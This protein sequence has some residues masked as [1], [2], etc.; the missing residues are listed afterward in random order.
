M[1]IRIITERYNPEI[2]G[3][4]MTALEQAQA[5]FDVRGCETYFFVQD[6]VQHVSFVLQMVS[7]TKGG[8]EVAGGG[9]AAAIAKHGGKVWISSDV[10]DILERLPQECRPAFSAL[11]TWRNDVAD[12]MKVK[13]YTVAENKLLERLALLVPQS[14]SELEDVWHCGQ[15]FRRKYGERIIELLRGAPKMP[16]G[17]ESALLKEDEV[18]SKF[19]RKKV[20][21]PITAHVEEVHS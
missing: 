9:R 21:P 1:H 10:G 5:G 16:E 6:G 2:A 17:F 4:D 19:D 20:G 13:R 3:F 8:L 18:R 11:V 15:E 7:A 14:V 12:S